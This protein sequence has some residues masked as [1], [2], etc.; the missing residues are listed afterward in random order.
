MRFLMSF[1]QS[2]FYQNYQCQSNSTQSPNSN[3]IRVAH[4][5]FNATVVYWKI[6]S[7]FFKDGL[8][9]PFLPSLEIVTRTLEEINDPDTVW[10]VRYL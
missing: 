8:R 3:F 10:R 4:Y 5:L 1:K 6:C 2:E 9:T 7:P